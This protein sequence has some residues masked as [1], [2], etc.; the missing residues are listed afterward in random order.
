MKTSYSFLDLWKKQLPYTIDDNCPLYP[1]TPFVETSSALK[2][3]I[4]AYP[5]FIGGMVATARFLLTSSEAG[6]LSRW[7]RYDQYEEKRLHIG[8]AVN[9]LALSPDEKYLAAACDDYT[10]KLYTLPDLTLI[11]TLRG[12]RGYVSKVAFTADGRL[13]SI[14]KDTTAR[15]WEVET[16]KLLH[17][18]EGHPEWIYALAVHPNKPLAI[19]A[20]LNS[21]LK[22]WDLGSGQCLR[23]LVEG[24]PMHYIMGMTVGGNNHSEKGNKQAPKCA[25]WLPNGK[26]VTCSKEVVVWQ[27][28][29][30]AILWKSEPLSAGIKSAFYDSSRDII[31]TA[32]TTI[33]G[34]DAKTGKHL[35]SEVGHEGTQIYSCYGQGWSSFFT[36]DK[37]GTIK[38]WQ[39]SFLGRAGVRFQHSSSIAGLV[40]VPQLGKIVSGCFDHTV[41]IWD[42]KGQ[43]LQ[44]L[45]NFGYHTYPLGSIPN[46]EAYHLISTQGKLVI[47]DIEKLEQVKVIALDN[48]LFSADGVYWLDETNALI[49]SLSYRPRIVNIITEKIAILDTPFGFTKHW[50]L[51]DGTVLFTNYP[52]TPLD[53]KN[54]GGAAIL[55]VA[56]PAYKNDNKIYAPLVLFDIATKKIKRLLW[57]RV[58]PQGKRKTHYPMRVLHQTASAFFVSYN[59]GS[60]VRWDNHSFEKAVIY[61]HSIEKS[62]MNGL[63]FIKDRCLI[64]DGKSDRVFDLNIH[65]QEVENWTALGLKKTRI[66]LMPN[67]RYVIY[68]KEL[69]ELVVL[70]IIERKVVLREP[71]LKLRKLYF[72]GDNM[73]VGTEKGE[74]YVFEVR[75]VM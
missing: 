26:V 21:N 64:F 55:D 41:I 32:S 24:S 49:Y 44:Q 5:K 35:F 28:D 69:S 50:D 19:T 22:L 2:Q 1:I 33:D 68:Q 30:W 73:I 36:G 51:G 31:I 40:S 63:F 6:Y 17:C 43:A 53:L 56:T 10:V 9:Y 13:V 15:V 60:I 58:P 11:K 14:S 25:L 74:V 29:T 59:D 12:H 38:I 65:T 39:L 61:Q 45:K 71:F 4:K 75:G 27:E 62:F 57:H 16:G 23:D 18:L 48:D 66:T 37:E 7:D 52:T 3:S 46:N 70:D 42:E 72:E 20:S 47:I 8:T 34:W 54:K 67:P